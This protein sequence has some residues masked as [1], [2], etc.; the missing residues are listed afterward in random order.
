MARFILF[1]FIA[2]HATW[3]LYIPTVV[4]SIAIA[5]YYQQNIQTN[6]DNSIFVGYFLL[7]APF[8]SW[9]CIVKYLNRIKEGQ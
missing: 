9:I 4:Y 1:S 5:H 3:F 8:V 6:V 7:A 2:W